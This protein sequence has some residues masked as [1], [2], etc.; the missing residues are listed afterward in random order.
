M[1]YLPPHIDD[2]HLLSSHPLSIIASASYRA[3]ILKRRVAHLLGFHILHLTPKTTAAILEFRTRRGLTPRSN[4]PETM[5]PLATGAV[6]K[7]HI[8]NVFPRTACFVQVDTLDSVAIRWSHSQKHAIS[9]HT[10][11]SVKLGA[12]E[13][14][15][16]HNDTTSTV[17]ASS[18]NISSLRRTHSSKFRMLTKSQSSAHF[19]K[20]VKAVHRQ[21]LVQYNGSKGVPRVL[22]LQL[23]KEKVA[24]WAE[25]L[26][27][28]VKKVPRIASPSY[29]RWA[30]SCMV[31]TSRRGEAGVLRRSELGSLL[32]RANSSVRLSD[33]KLAE[34]QHFIEGVEQHLD[35]PAWLRAPRMGGDGDALLGVRTITGL[36]L[37]LCTYST[38]IAGLFDHYAEKGQVGLDNWLDFVRAEQLGH[39]YV[40]QRGQSDSPPPWPTRFCAQAAELALAETRFRQ[41]TAAG[42]AEAPTNNG[43]KLLQFALQLLSPQNDAVALASDSIGTLGASDS[44]AAANGD[45]HIPLN[46]PLSHYWTACSHNT[47]I[48]AGI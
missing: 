46:E 3:L 12:Q 19:S 13:A 30:L 4:V 38:E 25:G 22:E 27:M 48:S 44:G 41:A 2:A 35:V 8:A 20:D 39:C 29:W 28:L 47:C 26:Q 43:L 42:S 21:L 36:L 33:E 15:G 23:P 16:S 9:L 31:A 11:E 17:C 7:L 40:G 14:L 32:K 45:A 6:V 24:S 34:A 37:W 18:R 10:V 1:P 5:L